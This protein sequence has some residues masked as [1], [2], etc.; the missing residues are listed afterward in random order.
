MNNTI[1]GVIAKTTAQSLTDLE[2]YVV[3]LNSSGNVTRTTAATD[4]PFGIVENGAAS[5]S[6][7]DISP[8]EPGAQFRAKVSANV[9]AGALLQLDGSN[10]G[11]L[12][13][14]TTGRAW[15]MA[16]AATL[17]GGIARVRPLAASY[18]ATVAAT[19]VKASITGAADLTA[20]K[21]ALGPLVDD[22]VAALA[23]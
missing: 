1:K 13:T 16:E 4:V 17:A 10:S 9:A 21:A 23:R 15:F 11:Q 8:L 6:L 12:V 18:P 7:A 2:G 14:A 22:V 20:L 19:A 5:G 3:K